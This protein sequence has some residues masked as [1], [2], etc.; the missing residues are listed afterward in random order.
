MTKNRKLF[1]EID[2]RSGNTQDSPT[3]TLSV[4]QEFWLC[5][6][7]WTLLVSLVSLILV[8]GWT[9]LTDSGLSIVEW[10]PITGMI[11]PLNPEG[12]IAEFEKYKSIP[13]FKL[14]NFAITMEEFKFIYWWE[15]GHRQLAR[16]IGLLWLVGFL[17]F[18]IRKQIP[19]RWTFY[20]FGIGLLGALQAFLGWWMVS[21]GLDGQ[22]VD[23]FSYRLAI[24][25]TMA[26]IILALIFWAILFHSESSVK[27][28]ESRRY[29]NKF[30]VNVLMG[31]GFLSYIQLALGALVAGIDAGR[32]YNDW[33]L[34]NGNWVPVDLFE[35]EPFLTNFF[36]N[37]G[38]VQFN[39]RLTAYLLFFAV[40]IIWWTNRKSPYY[41]VRVASNYLMTIVVVQMLLGVITVLYSA[42]LS[43]ASLHQFT[44]ILF[45]L[46]YI[47]L[48]FNTYYPLSQEIRS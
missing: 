3:E 10:K 33:P 40:S 1:E 2:E 39:H 24:H 13:E 29:R 46:A 5:I 18:W 27:I 20:F 36:E 17:I 11:P 8:G 14:V 12:W 23:V 45:I 34:M 42:P 41:K 35:Y 22:V 7:L 47:N 21:S 19:E 43:L 31:L 30:S 38:L 44:A 16:F 6:W 32:S 25:L 48:L 9:R 15:W 4:R 37:A 26:F 28:F